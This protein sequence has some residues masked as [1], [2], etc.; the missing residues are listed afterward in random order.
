VIREES[1]AY[2]PIHDR[3]RRRTVVPPEAAAR[4]HSWTPES[5][6]A[7]CVAQHLDVAIR[8]R[9]LI[10]RFE[11]VDAHLAALAEFVGE[12]TQDGSNVDLAKICRY[13]RDE[14]QST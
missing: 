14:R 3:S 6:I 12:A 2:K 11:A 7:D 13:H 5:L 1:R 10:E 8:H 9:A 4:A